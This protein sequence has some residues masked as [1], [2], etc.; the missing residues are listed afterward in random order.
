MLRVAWAALKI[1]TIRGAPGWLSQLGLRL[2]VSAQIMVSRF[3]EFEPHVVLHADG[4]EPAWDSL[5]PLLSLPPS[6]LVLSLSLSK[7]NKYTY[8]SW[9]T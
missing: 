2:L 5:S 1:F 4:V 7:I 9:P 3:R 8:N 6:P